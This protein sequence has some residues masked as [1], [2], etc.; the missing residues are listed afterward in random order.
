MSDI[1]DT[2]AETPSTDSG[3]AVPAKPTHP[4]MHWYVV[5]AYSGMEKAVERM[6][7]LGLIKRTE[8]PADR[9]AKKLALTTKGR[10]LIEKYFGHWHSWDNQLQSMD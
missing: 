1:T 6:V 7:Q 10:A 4:D 2:A 5:H 8:D 3:A 9:R